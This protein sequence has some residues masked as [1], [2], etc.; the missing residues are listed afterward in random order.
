[1]RDW[2]ECAVVTS[3]E[4]QW[5]ITAAELYSRTSWSWVLPLCS[6]FFLNVLNRE[7]SARNEMLPW[8]WREPGKEDDANIQRTLEDDER[9]SAWRPAHPKFNSLAKVATFDRILH[10]SS[11]NLPAQV[12]LPSSFKGWE[13]EVCR[14]GGL[15]V[16]VAMDLRAPWS[17]N[18]SELRG[19]HG[20]ASCKLLDGAPSVITEHS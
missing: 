9:A 18:I 13:Q 17:V 11:W 8:K 3:L 10:L 5:L 4:G 19:L 12:S 16:E 14:R 1:M 15:R 7:A 2:L 20:A 6:V